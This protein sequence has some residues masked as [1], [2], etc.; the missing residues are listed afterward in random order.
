MKSVKIGLIGFG[1][2][3]RGVYELLQQ[4]FN[5]IAEKIGVEINIVKICDVN[6]PSTPSEIPFT[7]N[8]QEIT[9]DPQIDTV[10]ELI[11][12]IDPS[13]NIILSSLKNKKNVV[14]ANKKLLAELGDEIFELA[15]KNKLKLGF[16]AAIGGGIPCL[17]ALRTGLVANN[18]SL[19]MGILNGTTNYILTKMEDD[20]LSFEKA[21][22]QA[23]EKG[24]A[25]A[26]PTF[27]IEGFDAGHKISLLAMMTYGKKIDYKHIP[28]EGITKISSIDINYAHDMGYTIKLLGIARREGDEIDIRVHP[29][30]MPLKH[31][32]ASVR[33]EFNAIMYHGDMTDSI[34]LTGKGA[35]SMPT[36]SAVISDIVQIVQSSDDSFMNVKLNGDAKLIDKSKLSCR[37]YL[38]ISTLDRSG[39][40]SSI[41]GVFGK[42]NISIASVIQ[43]ETEEELIPL[44]ILTHDA[45][46]A[47]I[48]E[49][50]NEIEAFDFVKENITLIRIEDSI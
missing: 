4:N 27:D 48:I 32:L 25:E 50:K 10:V 16:E 8:W 15:Y 22:Q 41:S 43:K 14:T 21:L 35:G 49:A 28:I 3:G 26:D 2:V 46:E 20:M 17:L 36:A 42:H 13:K 24:F 40:L 29:A 47:D 31:P 6:A 23:Q 45:N 19:I 11:G 44:I 39:I 33:N 5:L 30:M 37:Y 34:V 12:G 38:R 18:I 9:D 7:N 1:T